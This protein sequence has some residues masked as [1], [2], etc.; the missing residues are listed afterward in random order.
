METEGR[1]CSK[2]DVQLT[3]FQNCAKNADK[4]V[5]ESVSAKTDLDNMFAAL[6]KEYGVTGSNGEAT[7]AAGKTTKSTTREIPWL[8]SLTAFCHNVSVVGVRYVA[9][10]SASPYRRLVWATMVLV[11]VV[12]TAYQI[13]SR[14]QYYF[15]HPVNV[16]IRDEY[17]NEMRFPTLTICSENRISMKKMKSAGTIV[18]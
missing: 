5:E 7:G 4:L 11:G 2:Y 17:V 10:T 8:A 12:F 18:L 13:Q 1:K 16:V 15:S 3:S 9:N 14:I 6:D